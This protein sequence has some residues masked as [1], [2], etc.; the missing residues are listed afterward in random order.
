M[1]QKY[2]AEKERLVKESSLKYKKYF[3]W[4][5]YFKPHQNFFLNWLRNNI[6]DKNVAILDIGCGIGFLALRLHALGYNNYYG[7]DHAFTSSE[8]IK[9]LEVGRK[10]LIKFGLK[11]RF[12]VE[13]ASHTHFEDGQFDV[14]CVLDLAYNK[15][16]QMDTA[17]EEIH[18]I[19][20]PGGH[21]VMDVSCKHRKAYANL[22]TKEEMKK[23]LSGFSVEFRVVPKREHFKLGVVAR[24]CG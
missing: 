8:S 23:Y 19:L 16:F 15:N 20:K 13:R 6:K 17:C 18:R 1:K 10:L 2:L 21:L 22:Y 11:P 3:L 7:I 12:W 5:D 14:V 4:D 24:K 9:Q